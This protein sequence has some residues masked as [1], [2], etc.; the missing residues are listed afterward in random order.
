M[1][2]IP[3]ILFLMVI[4]STLFTSLTRANDVNESTAIT[5]L[6]MRDKVVL[7]K[8]EADGIKYSIKNQ[9]GDVL[10]ANLNE[11]ELASRYPDLYETIRPALASPDDSANTGIWAGM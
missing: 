10:S 7:I 5:R 1:R 6:Q 8:N 2:K 11:T 9:D 3:V 4:V